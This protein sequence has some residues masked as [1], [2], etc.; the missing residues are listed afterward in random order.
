M[1]EVKNIMKIVPRKRK[2]LL[3]WLAGQ[4]TEILMRICKVKSVTLATW[5][6]K[7]KAEKQAGNISTT[8]EQVEL[9]SLLD[10]V[11]AIK[12]EIKGG[13]TEKA[14]ELRVLEAKEKTKARKAPAT[15]LISKNYL[16]LIHSLRKEG[17][18]W[19]QV[20]QYLITHHHKKFAFSTIRTA[21]LAEYGTNSV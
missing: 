9:A 21:Y 17:L 5:Q 16:Q 10:A 14:Y 7:Y 15:T 13:K 12:R 2:E 18:S 6:S 4:N 19:R 8:I 20:Q 11:T 3:Q 1:R